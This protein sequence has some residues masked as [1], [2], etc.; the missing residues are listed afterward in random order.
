MERTTA[1]ELTRDPVQSVEQPLSALE[2]ALDDPIQDTPYGVCLYRIGSSSSGHPVRV[3]GRVPG[4]TGLYRVGP[5]SG[6]P[7]TIEHHPDRARIEADLAA[8]GPLRV[9]ARRWGVSKDA[10]ARHKAT[11]LPARA[12]RAVEARE[13]VEAEGLLSRLETGVQEAV[14][15]G[16]K[17]E[18]AGDLGTTLKALREMTRISE[19]LLDVAGVLRGSRGAAPGGGALHLHVTPEH[20]ARIAAAYLARHRVELPVDV[21]GSRVES[22]EPQGKPQQIAAGVSDGCPTSEEPA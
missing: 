7:S 12:A 6:R 19:I 14:R 20:G 5:M 10:L 22:P 13:A 8:G 16:K 2:H 18:A 15:I 4:C 11:R 1:G 17:A 9:I 21:T 3:S